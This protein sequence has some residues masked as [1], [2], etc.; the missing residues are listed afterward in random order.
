MSTFRQLLMSKRTHVPGL[1][2]GACAYGKSNADE[3]REYLR[4]YSGHGRDI[5]LYNFSFAGMSGF[6]GYSQDW[7]LRPNNPTAI[8]TTTT[9]TARIK[10]RID[11]K[12]DDEI[13]GGLLLYD[14]LDSSSLDVE[15]RIN[16][17][18]HGVVVRQTENGGR[19]AVVLATINAGETGSFVCT[20]ENYNAGK[21]F[22][23]VSVVDP[24]PVGGSAEFTILPQ[25]PGGLVSDGV[26]DYGQCIKG[27][28]LP[29]DYTVVAVR[30]TL[31]E[32]SVDSSFVAKSSGVNKGAFLL[33]N[34]NSDTYCYGQVTYNLHPFPPLFI[35]QTKT[36]YCGKT[37]TPGTSTDTENDILC[38]FRKR[39]TESSDH[40]K[41]VF[42]DLRIYD[43]SLTDDELQ[44]VKDEMMSDYYRH[45]EP[46]KYTHW[47]ADWDA[48]GRSND[49]EEPMRS[50][51]TD[52]ATGKVIDLHNYAFAGMS[53][54]G[55]YYYDFTNWTQINFTGNYTPTKAVFFNRNEGITSKVLIEKYVKR[56]TDAGTFSYPG[57]YIRVN[58]PNNIPICCDYY[59]KGSLIG[60]LIDLHEG[61]NYIPP[62][63]IE[64]ADDQPEGIALR[65]LV[66]K[67][68]EGDYQNVD[69]TIEQ[70]PRYPGA[71][72]SD[73]V[74]DFI[75][76]EEAL[77]EVGSVL[78]HW[79]NIGLGRGRYVYNT[80]V[81]DPGRLYMYKEASN[82]NIVMGIPGMIIKSGSISVFRRDPLVSTMPL[83]NSAGGNNCPIYRLI[84]IREQLD[85]QQVEALKWKVDKEYRDWLKQNG[86]RLFPENLDLAVTPE[87]LDYGKEGGVKQITITTDDNWTIS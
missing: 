81:D 29:D 48:K 55:G 73:G 51:W 38:L 4:D 8:A 9:T 84:F 83:F 32:K 71:L 23:M 53:G 52:K 27:F 70:L 2:L 67:T 54:W 31:N 28:S 75:R 79:K 69:I 13:I 59:Y 11:N 25:Y 65:F 86:Y 24:I 50:T 49:E 39:I 37:I 76:S 77:G 33:E 45:A 34:G 1:V 58:N 60:T 56:N 21:T 12:K 36:S 64:V 6:G 78:V 7:N 72:C 47:V 10:V 41:G 46:M 68:Y 87:S 61:L 82:D 18:S 26:D 14:D 80:G 22:I 62:Q 66:K 15:T 30:K 16:G 40:Y 43:H 17:G 74:D 35:Y 19:N 42:Y 44:L 5:R 85:E 20:S 57:F 63:T 3:D